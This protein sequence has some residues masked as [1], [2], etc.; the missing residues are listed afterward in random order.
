MDQTPQ[1]L[2]RQREFSLSEEEFRKLRDL[3]RSLTGIVLADHKKEMLYSRLARRLRQ[4]GMQSFSQYC[5]LLDSAEADQETGHLVNAVTTNLTRFYRESH[6]FDFLQ[7]HI[8]QITRD[9]ARRSRDRAIRIWSAGCSSGEEPYSIATTLL[10][11]VADID[12]WDLRILATD[13][14]TNMLDQGRSGRYPLSAAEG[15]PAAYKSILENQSRVRDGRLTLKD[16]VRNLV[17]F[18]QLNLL[19]DW[20]MTKQYDVIFC[21]NVLIYF[22]NPTKDR[23]VSRYI[24]L[25]RPGGLLFLGH[26]ESL[27]QNAHGLSLIGRTAYRKGSDHG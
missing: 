22:D 11:R 6:H 3:I 15:L 25:L 21:R 24:N 5:R 10:S 12:N 19:Q 4:L 8:R 16:S 9:P 13:L 26:S 1:T 23:L 18:K 17:H 20:P 7:D 27:F 2:D 14:D